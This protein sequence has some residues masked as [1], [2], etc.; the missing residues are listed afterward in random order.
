MTDRRKDVGA[1]ANRTRGA[2]NV[3]ATNAAKNT[4]EAAKNAQPGAKHGKKGK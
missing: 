4:N 3:K 2:A 1:K